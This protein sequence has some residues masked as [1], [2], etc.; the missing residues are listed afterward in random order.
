[1]QKAK[2]STKEKILLATIECIE[3]EGIHA[4]TIRK[5]AKIANVN[6][7]SVNYHFN[8]KQN[9]LHQLAKFT[10]ENM[11]REWYMQLENE[12][13]IETIL[14][15]IAKEL[16]VGILQYPNLSRWHFFEIFNKPENII[17]QYLIGFIEKLSEKINKLYPNLPPQNIQK[18]IIQ[19]FSL[20]IFYPLFNTIF[21]SAL[22]NNLLNEQNIDEFVSST[23]NTLIRDYLN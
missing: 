1:M 6:I 23:I 4:V 15:F 18:L 9:L 19:F 2:T 8:S 20:F 22:K 17:S 12:N 11:V 5:I 10:A 7:A 16:I 14:K 13:E 3:K 21:N